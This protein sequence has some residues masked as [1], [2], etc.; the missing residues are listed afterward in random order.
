[1]TASVPPVAAG[2]PDRKAPGPLETRAASRTIAAIPPV[3]ALPPESS[4]PARP[5]AS[6]VQ[7]SPVAQTPPPVA[8]PAE[9]ADLP[10]AAAPAPQTAALFPPGSRPGP[11]PAPSVR[12][13][14]AP[15]P[16]KFSLARLRERAQEGLPAAQ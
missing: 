6:F 10:Q 7:T 8:R 1:M 2:K 4:M 14:P 13:S 11:E 3:P 16:E 15:P 12:G 5:P 9:P